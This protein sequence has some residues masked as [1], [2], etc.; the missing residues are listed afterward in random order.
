VKWRWIG[1][2]PLKQ[3]QPPTPPT[4]DP[5][6]PTPA[7]AARIASE[8]WKDPDWGMFVWLAMT[9][10]ARRGELCAL[11]W[12]RIDFVASVLDIRSSIAQSSGRTWEKDTKTHQR[13]RIVL[14]AQTLTLLRAYLQR[15]VEQAA[16]LRVE[17]RDD[18]FVFSPEPDGSAW[19]K[20][21]L[22]NPAL[23]ADVRSAGLGYAPSPAPP[24]L[25]NRADRR[26]CRHTHRRRTARPRRRWNYDAARLQRVGQRGRPASGNLTRYAHARATNYGD[27]P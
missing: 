17:L 14:D 6:P 26:W 13:R 24:L 3:A 5:Q 11:R 2:N 12:N 21:R 10:G 20:T 7:Q 15:R 4:P 1:V 9:T 22:R 8:A 19:P 16:E 27:Q 25:G 23:C 18:A